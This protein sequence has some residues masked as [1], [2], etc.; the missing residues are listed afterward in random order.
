MGIQTGMRPIATASRPEEKS[1]TG[2]QVGQLLSG[3]TTPKAIE[4][5]LGTRHYRLF[6]ID[7]SW[8]VNG[9]EQDSLKKEILKLGTNAVIRSAKDEAGNP[10]SATVI[11]IV[12]TTPPNKPVVRGQAA[13]ASKTPT[14]TWA[15]GGG[16][17]NGTFKYWLD[18]DDSSK[19]KVTTDTVFT[20]GTEQTEGIHTLFLAE[21]DRAGNWSLAGRFAT[22]IDLSAPGMPKVSTLPTS[23][24][25]LRN[26]KWI[27]SSGGNGVGTYQYKLDNGNLTSGATATTDTSYSPL[28]N[29]ANGPHTLYVQ[30]RDSAGNWSVSGSAAILVDT[31]A[32]GAPVVSAVQTSPTN[33][34]RPTWN[35][36]GGGGGRGFYRYKIGD[37]VWASGGLQGSAAQ[38]RPEA[39]LAEGLRTLYVAEQDSAGNWST[40]GSFGVTLDLT[41]P[42]APKMD[43][44]PY[45]PLNNLKPKWSWATGGGGM[46]TYRCRIDN[47][48]LPGGTTISTTNFMSPVDLS[49]GL[50]SLYVQEK[51]AAGNWSQTSKRDLVVAMRSATGG[52]NFLSVGYSSIYTAISKTGE[53]YISTVDVTD[54][55]KSLVMKYTGSGWTKLGAS[56]LGLRAFGANAIAVSES[57]VP[58]V[59]YNEDAAKA[60]KGSV[61][62]FNGTGW[63]IVGSAGFT[64]GMVTYPALAIGP[65]EIPY[66]AFK[67]DAHESKLSIMRYFGGTWEYHGGQPGI[68]AGSTDEIRITIGGNGKQYVVFLNQAGPTEYTVLGFSGTEWVKMASL[69]SYGSLPSLAISSTGVLYAAFHNASNGKAVVAKWNG[70]GFENV[71]SAG[72]SDASVNG[73][74][75]RIGKNDVPYLAF[76]DKYP[77]T[78]TPS[79]KPTVMRYVG[80]KWDSVG[81]QRF[82]DGNIWSMEMVL[83]PNDVPNLLFNAQN[84]GG[85]ANLMRGV[86]DN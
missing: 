43:S 69:P 14:W 26:P 71:G 4:P 11:V 56:G 24:T 21:R 52:S 33:E 82:L 70:T 45:S 42:G 41:A 32:P 61:A 15:T 60:Y 59:V 50:H 63:L 5:A 78:G 62:K 22:R 72:L 57:G 65:G 25:N 40:A 9:K 30:E 18:V 27:W 39:V 6:S 73:I 34:S 13:T 3:I 55:S 86:F 8:T 77:D 84:L 83:D 64:D 49:E 51:D 16:G 35:W 23:P 1:T 31:I 47:I 81:P 75:L 28:A 7:V 79:A 53:I 36:V 68:S 76:E 85:T 66:I 48:D 54:S 80:S 12:D 2:F 17:G 10:Y 58:F 44:T 19:G 37:T 38:Y 29:L 20:P 67:D 46:G 74:S